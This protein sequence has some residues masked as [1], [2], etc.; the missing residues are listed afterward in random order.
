M[1]KREKE[2]DLSF[3][4]PNQTEHK[5]SK[6]ELHLEQVFDRG[7]NFRQ[8]IIQI[9]GDIDEDKFKL[10]DGALSEMEADSR[11]AIT[12]RINSCGGSVYDALAIVGR[13]KTSKCKIITEGFGCVMSAATMILACGNLRR[14]SQ[15]AWFMSHE[16]RY[17]V[18][19]R[20]HTAAV[21]F[22]KQSE[23]EE[24]QWAECMAKFTKMDF[25]FWKK[26]GTGGKDA[27]FIAKELLE[28]GIVDEII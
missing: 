12:I 6:L 25:D 20:S 3:N 15:F 7:V 4:S 11:K 16:S 14:I 17:E 24:I 5:V 21:N 8:R 27:Y 10:I 2:D 18:T 1:S 19:D 13:I 22:V 9:V 23:R 28:M 26:T